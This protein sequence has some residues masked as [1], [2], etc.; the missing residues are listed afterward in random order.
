MPRHVDFRPSGL[1]EL[2]LLVAIAVL[3]GF[4]VA[5]HIE[6]YFYR[7]K[8]ETVVTQYLDAVRAVQRDIRH[9]SAGRV[10][11]F[12]RTDSHPGLFANHGK[13]LHHAATYAVGSKYAE[14]GVIYLSHASFILAP[15][16][17]FADHYFQRDPDLLFLYQDWSRVGRPLQVPAMEIAGDAAQD[18]RSFCKGN[19]VVVT[20]GMNFDYRN[21]NR[22]IRS[23]VGVLL[24]KN[25]FKPD[26][27]NDLHLKTLRP[28]FNGFFDQ[29]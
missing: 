28:A 29:R 11:Y 5:P 19:P 20:V 10:L 21:R 15:N 8:A 3:L 1:I 4:A 2:L 23:K 25:G 14:P 16:I 26:N 6:A 24:R 7:L 18:A 9:A 12:V 17:R 13:L 22:N 27:C